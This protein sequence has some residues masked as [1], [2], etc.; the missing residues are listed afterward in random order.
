MNSKTLTTGEVAKICNVATRT[1]AK[2]ID[3]GELKGFRLPGGKNRRVMAENL[4]AFMKRNNIPLELT[5]EEI[6]NEISI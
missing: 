2:W 4:I 6:L 5:N 1:V 3:S